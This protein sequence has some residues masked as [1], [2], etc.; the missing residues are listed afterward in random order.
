VSSEVEDELYA[1]CA[2]IGITLFTVS[3]RD[4]LKRHHAKCLTF[5]GE[6]GA[7]LWQDISQADKDRIV[8]A[9]KHSLAQFGGENH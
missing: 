1:T 8:Q 6:K 9:H 7:W 4:Y 2:K 5:V 3:H